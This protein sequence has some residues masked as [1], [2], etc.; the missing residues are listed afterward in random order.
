MGTTVFLTTMNGM[1]HCLICNDNI[2]TPKAYNLKRHYEMNHLSCDKYE[3]PM[4]VSKLKEL[5]VNLSQQQTFHAKSQKG[6]VATVTAGYELSR[7]IAKNR[8]SYTEGDKM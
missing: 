3:G 8:K 7:M 4:R 6:N 5:M 1:I 2:C